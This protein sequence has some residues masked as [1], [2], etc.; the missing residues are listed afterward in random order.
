MTIREIKK[1]LSKVPKNQEDYEFVVAC[2]CPKGC[3]IME[4][5]AAPQERV[6][7]VKNLMKTQ[8]HETN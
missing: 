1:V 2:S 3:T 4:F 7:E 5:Y 6:K 8:K